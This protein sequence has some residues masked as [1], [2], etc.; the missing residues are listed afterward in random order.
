MK[1]VNKIKRQIAA[2][3]STADSKSAFTLIE[4]LVVIAIIA[5]L[6]AIL[7]PVFG[8]ARENARRS[9][10]QSNMKQLGLGIMQYTQDY[11]ERMPAIFLGI[12]NTASEITWRYAIYPYVKNTQVYFCPS[13]PIPPST[14]I[15]SP[16]PPDSSNLTNGTATDE[17]RGFSGYSAHRIHRAS[18]APTPPMDFN[19]TGTNTVTLSSFTSPS[20]TFTLVEIKTLDSGVSSFYY[21]G[22]SS[23]TLNTAPDANG[24]FPLALA[25]PRHLEGY[26]F[27]Y[28]DGHVKWLPPS[29]ATDTSGG[30]N[31]GSPWSIE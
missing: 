8:R 20:E 5:I 15:W 11:D 3:A 29:K 25:G 31:D 14:P 19:G 13:L 28:A 26:N 7:F 17:V 1:K 12:N 21:D 10:C 27:L 16:I 4:L 9:S 23:N 24:K 18:N 2:V 22:N 30:G 6:A